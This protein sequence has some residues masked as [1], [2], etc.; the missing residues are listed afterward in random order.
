MQQK[1]HVYSYMT[2]VNIIMQ[3]KRYVY[4]FMTK[5]LKVRC[6]ITKKFVNLFTSTWMNHNSRMSA[7]FC[8]NA[9]DYNQLHAV[10]YTLLCGTTEFVCRWVTSLSV[11]WCVYRPSVVYVYERS[12][13]FAVRITGES[14]QPIVCYCVSFMLKLY[15]IVNRMLVWEF[16]VNWLYVVRG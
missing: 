13:S 9:W 5:P 15:Y 7:Q 4:S 11:C 14:S 8:D 16:T 10:R 12:H 3:Q 2:K 1:R 6:T